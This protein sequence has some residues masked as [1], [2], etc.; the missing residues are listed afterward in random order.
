MGK[1]KSK[2]TK[3]ELNYFKKLVLK[4]REDL[5][6]ELGYLRET[7]MSSTIKESSGDHSSYSFHMADQGTDSMEREKAFLF[8]SREG[9]YLE[10]LNQALARIEEGTFG[11]CFKCGKLISKERLKAVP[12]TTQC[13]D[14]KKK[15]G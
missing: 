6:K 3:K 13:V 9:H 5:M 2:L 15:S 12:I 1:T 14:C 8:V 4:K 10:H 7:A 11:I